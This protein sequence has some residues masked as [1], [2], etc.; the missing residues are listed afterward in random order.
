MN[1]EEFGLDKAYAYATKY[2]ADYDELCNLVGAACMELRTENEAL[3]AQLAA[4]VPDGWKW[5]PVKPTEE[6]IAEVGDFKV[7]IDRGGEQTLW[8]SEYE[9][10]YKRMLAAAPQPVAQPKQLPS[11]QIEEV[12]HFSGYVKW[13]PHNGAPIKVGDCLYTRQ[14]P[15]RV[16]LPRDQVSKLWEE[17]FYRVE[18]GVTPDFEKFARSIEAAH[19]IKE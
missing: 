1:A 12:G 14:Q 5:A 9:E 7:E 17:S 19:G 13:L 16:A 6:M 3:R 4:R 2:A 11:A 15:E 18:H 10:I 8:I